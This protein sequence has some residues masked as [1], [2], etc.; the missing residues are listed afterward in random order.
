MGR[1]KSKS[2]ALGIAGDSVGMKN[3]NG[4]GNGVSRVFAPYS[5][6]CMHGL[7]VNFLIVGFSPVY[8][9]YSAAVAGFD[10][11]RVRDASL[12]FVECQPNIHA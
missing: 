7:S 5:D 12:P 9:R 6:T 4:N 2:G 10:N 11:A 1:W 3:G 8:S